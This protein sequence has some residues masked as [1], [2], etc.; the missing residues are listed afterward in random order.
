[1]LG[2]QED[3]SWQ[4][5]PYQYS[6]RNDPETYI[7]T[8]QFRT[9][10]PHPRALSVPDS[11]EEAVFEAPYNNLEALV[12][13]LTDSVEHP[14]ERARII[15][16][17]IALNIAY[18]GEALLSQ[19]LFRED[20]AMTLTRRHAVCGGYARLFEYMSHLAD[21]EVETVTG[22]SRGYGV[23]LFD[24]RVRFRSRNA[25]AWNAVRFE[26]NWYLVDVTWN[27]GY[28]QD[29]R[30]MADYGTEYLYADPEHFIYTH[31]PQAPGW[32][33]TE[34]EVTRERFEA[35][36]HLRP[37]FF[38]SGLELHGSIKAVN[39]VE[40]RAFELPIRR[41]AGTRLLLVIRDSHGREVTRVESNLGETE[42]GWEMYPIR[43]PSGG[44][45]QVAIYELSGNESAYTYRGRF[46]LVAQ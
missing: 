34:Q 11:V 5:E 41:S 28:L 27:A 17:W 22:Y 3:D 32:Y 46:A 13:E 30:F 26:N 16:D 10:E 39:H 36:P 19:R 43:L 42:A 14:L 12:Q 15:H 1:M 38:Q 9:K 6:N 18:D 35:L 44:N 25:H 33:L 37:G 23:P 2:G 20:P 45:Y 31:Y 4:P 7:D 29:G 24:E 8:R 40:G 21:V